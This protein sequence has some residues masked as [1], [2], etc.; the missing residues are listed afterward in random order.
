MDTLP[1]TPGPDE[2]ATPW[3]VREML[4]DTGRNAARQLGRWSDALDLNAALIASMRDRAPRPPR[5]P[6]PGSTTTGRCSA[7]AAPTRR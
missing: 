5:S 1:A 4:L 7:S 2:T 3:N 6:R